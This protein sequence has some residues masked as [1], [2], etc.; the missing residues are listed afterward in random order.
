MNSK[1]FYVAPAII[2]MELTH[3]GVLCSSD[4][5]ATGIDP[6]NPEYDWSDMWN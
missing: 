4:R 1:E 6:L 5:D 3:E 2:E